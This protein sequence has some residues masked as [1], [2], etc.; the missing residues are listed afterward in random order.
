MTNLLLER[1]LEI[2]SILNFDGN[3]L[4]V[5]QEKPLYAEEESL[6]SQLD[7][8]HEIVER[9]K[10]EIE[11]I[12][13]VQH[14]DPREYNQHCIECAFKQNLQLILEGKI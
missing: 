2:N 13:K 14:T 5:E 4:T 11:S 1:L 12:D 9:L 7:A 8:E 10:A 3:G 6:K